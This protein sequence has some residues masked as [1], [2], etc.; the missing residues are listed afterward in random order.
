MNK[1]KCTSFNP[2]LPSDHN[3]IPEDVTPSEEHN[4]LLTKREAK[5]A[6]PADMAVCGEEDPGEALELLVRGDIPPNPK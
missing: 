3:V 5:A 6:S 2:A 1:K 4:F